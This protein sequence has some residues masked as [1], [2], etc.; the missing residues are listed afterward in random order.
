MLERVF[1]GFPYKLHARAHRVLTKTSA[2]LRR[3]LALPSR[4]RSSQVVT[5]STET[6][7]HPDVWHTW[8]P[9]CRCCLLL[10]LWVLFRFS[11]C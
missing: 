7:A 2:G 10:L 4:L 3:H 6:H 1:L 5:T 8:R 9:S 11:R